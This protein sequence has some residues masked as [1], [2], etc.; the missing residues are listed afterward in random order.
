MRIQGAVLE[1][2]GS[3]RPY[4]STTP[5]TVGTLELADPGPGEILIRIEAAGVCH[6]DLSVVNGSR[7]RPVPMLLGHEAAGIVEA[8]GAGVDDLP[9]GSRVVLTFLPRCGDCVACT[10]GGLAPCE[11]GSASNAAGTLLNGSLHLERG[12]ETIHHHLGVSGFATHAVVDRRS[13][14]EVSDD[15]PARV[16]ALLG[17]AVL[18]GGGAVVNAGKVTAGET[19]VIVGLGGVGM[20]ALLTGLAQDDVRVIAIDSNQDKLNRAADLGAHEAYLPADAAQVGITAEVVV[21]AVG[22]ARAFE[23]A[24]ALTGPGGRLVTVGLPSADDLATISPLTLVATGRTIIGSYL[25]SS[26]PSRDIPYFVDLWRS[27]RLP[28]EQLISKEIALED[29][30][31]AMDELADGVV[32]RQLI[33][34]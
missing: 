30:N 33:I 21:E 12:G 34:F 17:C 19:L 15:V 4:G 22:N 16:A 31:H 29:I 2:M 3:T 9:L 32:V 14:V 25:G 6:S 20:A 1:R 7:S 24:L 13:V 10:R 8:L 26:V 23:S 5:I 27:G 28:V 11:K 18:T